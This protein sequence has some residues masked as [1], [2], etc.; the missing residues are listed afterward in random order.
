MC[1]LSY[2]W[3]LEMPGFGSPDFLLSAAMEMG[4]RPTLEGS[5]P[6]DTE[7]GS[8][9]LEDGAAFRQYP[10]SLYLNR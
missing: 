8:K 9:R 6:K 10:G 4:S 1:A 5:L 3:G 7:P 2:T